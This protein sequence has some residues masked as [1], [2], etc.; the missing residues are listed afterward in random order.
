[1]RGRFVT[2]EGIEGS[3]KSTLIERLAA[4]LRAAGHDVLT[5]REPGG[6]Q[7]GRELRELLLHRGVAPAHATEALLMIA[8]RAEHAARVIRPALEAG[9]IVLCDRHG[10]ST[11]AYQGGGSGLDRTML[12]AMNAWA[13][14]GLAP[15]L[16]LLLDLPAEESIGRLSARAGANAPDRF[17][18]EPL[19]FHRRVR[20]AYL[21]LAHASPARWI[22]LD[23][24]RDPDAIF[25]DA[26][27]RVDALLGARTG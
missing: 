27:A 5:T 1:M 4:H 18:S 7:L 6:T 21:E 24:R 8:D 19:E 10:D 16:T 12:A 22:V 23:A 14:G 25:R 15:D 2:F 3:G 11:V 20:A 17:E 26:S 9:R 13:T